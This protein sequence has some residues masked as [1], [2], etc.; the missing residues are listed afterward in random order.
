MADPLCKPFSMGRNLFCV[1]SRKH[2]DDQPE[3]KEGKQRT[4]RKTLSEMAR[5]L[6]Q[7]HSAC[8]VCGR[9]YEGPKVVGLPVRPRMLPPQA[10]CGCALW[11]L[12][13]PVYT[14]Q[15]Q[16]AAVCSQTCTMHRGWLDLGRLH[17]LRLW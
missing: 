3:L 6:N 7:V 2:M 9:A 11:S 8:L 4:N 14:G 5:A 17:Q 10:A 12:L 16:A 1:H 13:L 15:Q